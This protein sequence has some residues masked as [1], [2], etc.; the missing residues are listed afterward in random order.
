MEKTY[1]CMACGKE[2]KILGHCWSCG[3]KVKVQEVEVVELKTMKIK[4]EKYIE[5]KKPSYTD[6]EMS[7]L[8]CAFF[9]TCDD[10]IHTTAKQ[11]FGRTCREGVIYI[12]K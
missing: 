6:P 7:C 10:T 11:V 9:C 8:S 5:V 2:N 3:V 12:R 4:G 1:V